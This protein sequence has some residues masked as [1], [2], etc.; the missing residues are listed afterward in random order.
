MSAK[1]RT[2]SRLR[3][4]AQER[5]K[6]TGEKYTAALAAVARG[7][8][9]PIIIA[10]A[11]PGLGTSFDHEGF[12]NK[13]LPY[14]GAQTKRIAV[15]AYRIA[16]R[17]SGNTMGGFARTAALRIIT[18]IGTDEGAK[19]LAGVHDRNDDWKVLNDLQNLPAAESAEV[20]AP[21]RNQMTLLAK[22]S[23]YLSEEVRS[24]LDL[25]LRTARSAGTRYSSEEIARR[26][27]R[28][29]RN[30]E[31]EDGGV[32][33]EII[34][35]LRGSGMDIPILMPDVAYE[36][37]EWETQEITDAKSAVYDI[38]YRENDRSGMDEE[39]YDTIGAADAVVESLIAGGARFPEGDR[40]VPRLVTLPVFDGESMAL[41][42]KDHVLVAGMSGTGKTV[43]VEKIART[44]LDAG[45]DV[46]MYSPY[47]L[48][49]TPT[50]LF[51]AGRAT[52]MLT[53]AIK[54]M[55]E[56]YERMN[57]IG[58][59]TYAETGMGGLTVVVDDVL[60]DEISDETVSAVAHL[61]RL[62]GAAGVRVVVS[63]HQVA[64]TTRDHLIRRVEGFTH[65]VLMGQSTH[66]EKMV[67]FDSTEI[68]TSLFRRG[69]GVYRSE[70]GEISIVTVPRP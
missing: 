21:L 57:E 2:S 61:T 3:A 63:T 41:G 14:A 68:E 27:A 18:E 69:Q 45:E 46:W 48:N 17:L 7:E 37:R 22:D 13:S 70:S 23:D 28:L 12:V 38:L 47:P 32:P 34:D 1:K 33:R 4:A 60:Y 9:P 5:M 59:S 42:M 35:A 66:A 25:I 29:L 8:N 30:P 39:K 6:V 51:E 64:K 24:K 65:R 15:A 16:S 10:E 44:L 50:R 19:L 62:G 40:T 53:E 56:R 31:A 26:S 43:L 67:M 55:H 20:L 52:D 58:A 49:V 54:I 36:P 11:R